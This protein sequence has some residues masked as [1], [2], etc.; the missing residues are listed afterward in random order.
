MLIGITMGD[1]C[2]L[3][4]E[5]LLRSVA[6]DEL[7]QPCL[8]FGD[9]DVLEFAQEKLDLNVTFRSISSV[10]EVEAGRV[11]VLDCGQLKRADVTIGKI[12]AKSGNAAVR[13]VQAAVEHALDHK[14]QSIVTLPINKEASRHSFPDFQG[15]TEFIADMCGVADY[16]MML[17]APKLIVTHVSTHVPIR[18]AID[19]VK[20]DRVLS[21]I[22]LTHEAVEKLRPRAKIA[23]AG[24]NPH[25]GE[26]GAFGDED[27]EEIA[28]AVLDAQS[29]GI[30]AHGPIPPDTLFM[31]AVTGDYDAVVCMYHDQGHIPMKLHG[32]HDT[33]NVTLGLPIIRTSVDHGT[34]FDIAYKGIASAQNF[35]NAFNL[36][37]QLALHHDETHL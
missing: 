9:V 5:I 22:R 34:G 27:M 24:L 18:T 2:G 37:V 13:Y 29:K 12:S 25:A 8:V 15:H 26:H 17:A 33:V 36:A 7:P 21:V 32:F 1:A 16:T 4:P 11:N 23:V 19:L 6:N 14:I 30:D 31:K 3:G 28:P 35:L 20:R 10:D